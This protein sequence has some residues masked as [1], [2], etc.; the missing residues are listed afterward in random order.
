MQVTF[1]E[2]AEK[3]EKDAAFAA[4]EYGGCA[5]DKR[6]KKQAVQSSF[7]ASGPP[8]SFLRWLYTVP[9]LP[10]GCSGGVLPSCFWLPK[11]PVGGGPSGRCPPPMPETI[12]PLCALL[13]V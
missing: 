1:V 3:R 10:P 8:V 6:Q 9:E 5:A 4:P 11:P 13:S 12:V 7:R 2:K